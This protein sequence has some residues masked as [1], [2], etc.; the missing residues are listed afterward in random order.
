M[1]T[2]G[3]AYGGGGASGAEALID[4]DGEIA[5]PAGEIAI[6]A[7]EKEPWAVTA[8]AE[9]RSWWAVAAAN[10]VADEAVER[11]WA[12]PRGEAPLIAPFRCS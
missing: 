4:L 9:K 10:S 2:S 3:E 6:P 8:H 7:D 11:S 5:I 1:S 12:S